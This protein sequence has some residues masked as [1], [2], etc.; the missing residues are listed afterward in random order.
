[1]SGA[2]SSSTILGFHGL[3]QNPPNQRP[4]MALLSCSR[5]MSASPEAVRSP[6]LPRGSQAPISASCLLIP[7]GD[8]DGQRTDRHPQ[9]PRP[10]IKSSANLLRKCDETGNNP[11]RTV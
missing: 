9:R 11:G 8:F 6:S 1:M 3:P 7:E 2:A 4:T 10:P 5:D